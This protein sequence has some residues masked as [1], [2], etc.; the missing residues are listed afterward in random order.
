MPISAIGQG[1]AALQACSRHHDPYSPPLDD[2]AVIAI[3]HMLEPQ[4]DNCFVTAA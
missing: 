4:E 3:P 2:N 1:R